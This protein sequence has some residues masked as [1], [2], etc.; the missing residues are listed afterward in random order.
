MPAVS[1]YFHIIYTYFTRFTYMQWV[2]MQMGKFGAT[3]STFAKKKKKKKKC[4]WVEWTSRR[5]TPPSPK[6][7]SFSPFLLP[8]GDGERESLWLVE[9]E[10]HLDKTNV[11]VSHTAETAARHSRK[12]SSGCVDM[13]VTYRPWW[14]RYTPA[15][16]SQRLQ[17]GG[18]I[19][20]RFWRWKGEDVY[21][22]L[23]T[24]SWLF[25]LSVVFARC[26]LGP[27]APTR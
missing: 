20:C 1:I 27:R 11:P 24:V 15:G 26:Y 17:R 6:I 9:D 14:G 18:K 19:C 13:N 12:Y 3:Q 23:H 2:S 4:V 10:K 16:V 21:R 7:P 22:A 8:C 5:S 25:V